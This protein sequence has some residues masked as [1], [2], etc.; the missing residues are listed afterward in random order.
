LVAGLEDRRDHAATMFRSATW[1]MKLRTK[2]LPTPSTA[3]TLRA[4]NAELRARLD[5]AEKTLR[6]IRAGEVDS[7]LEKGSIRPQLFLD[8]RVAEQNRFCGEMLAKVSDAVIAVNQEERVTFLNAAAERQYGVRAGDVLG[9][10]HTEVFTRLWPSPEAEAGMRTALSDR[11]EWHGELIH[12][13][14]DGRE[15]HIESSVTALRGPDGERA[16]VLTAIHDLTARKKLQAEKSE[17][18]RLL[19]TLLA[20]APIGFVFLDRNLRYVLINE[21][22]AEINGLPVAAHL[23]RT[24]AEIVPTLEAT[25]RKVTD[26]IL[27]TGQP[28]LDQEFTGETARAPGVTR[29]WSQSWYP[30][31]DERGEIVGFGAVVE[32]Y[33]LRKQAEEAVRR[34]ASIVECSY[35]ALFSKD[36][37][38]NITSWNRGAERMFG[39]RA[40]EIIGTSIMRLI[41]GAGQA[42]EY[43][44]QRKIADGRRGGAFEATR[45]A[46]D[47]RK[48]YASITASPMEDP[49][50]RVIGSSNVIR[51]ITEQKLTLDRLR[52]ATEM[53]VKAN[54]AKDRFLAA[55]SHELRTPLTPVLLIS[56]AHEESKELSEEVREDFAM[57]RRNIE[58]EAQ[59]I[60]DLL[61]VSRIQQGK[62]RFDFKLVDVHEAVAHALQ[63][64]RSEAEEK[65][66]AI[67]REL[68]ATPATINT[69]PSRL[70]QVLCNLL[71]NALKF[72]PRGGTITLGTAH[73]FD[74]LQI[75]VADNGAGIAAED[76]KRIF[77]PFEQV[78]VQQ[79]SEHRSLGLGLA[80]SSAI[81]SA[82]GGRIWAESPGLGRGATFH[83]RLPL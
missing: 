58:L 65:G 11:G 53:A 67:R 72:T 7:G 30:V 37:K 76:L 47:G 9:R 10:P 75:S 16:G 48:F 83:V 40:D 19:E 41:P 51:D 8:G 20:R 5:E 14:R 26:C 2:I 81:V 1:D 61:D 43:E 57:I 21:R 33:T 45:Q 27:A 49:A 17:A 32:E 36:L 68:R 66:I 23:G 74:G 42:E 50:G 62:M 29:F 38:G 70:R 3:Q 71:S 4:E 22:L 60:D 59:L 12:R 55:L 63:M 35:D 52:E 56:Q 25:L 44:L 18:L 15:L 80:I 13:T 64:L 82:L 34:L 39:Y 24:V 28:V 73:E 79:K 46:K 54:A 31:C 6:A 69:D 77:H 78:E